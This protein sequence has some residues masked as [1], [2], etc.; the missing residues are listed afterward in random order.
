LATVRSV[1]RLLPTATTPPSP[2]GPDAD[3]DVE[4]VVAA[5]ERPPPAGRPWVLVNMVASVDGA[6]QGT[7]AK[8]GTLSGPGDRR[9]FHA[10]RGIADM[11]LAGAGTVRA[12]N[13]GAPKGAA[14]GPRL[15]V[16]SGSLA[17]D[18][19]SRFF[20]EP[21]QPPVVL[22]TEEAVAAGRADDLAE[23]ADV[24]AVGD[25]MVDWDRALRLLREEL[26]VETLLV[27]G[28]PLLNG[29]LVAADLVDELRVTVSPLVAGGSARRIVADSPLTGSLPLA[30]ADVLEE[31]GFLFLRYLRVR[32]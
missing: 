27:E 15:A 17:L 8:S 5:E 24:H 14:P 26:A 9:L 16:V 7:D 32:H 29:H 6:S 22:T 1:R 4:A 30:L 2:A 13:Y 23:V 18:P 28:G 25:R 10:L 20:R 19:T 31:D 3:L 12:E 11:V 21:A